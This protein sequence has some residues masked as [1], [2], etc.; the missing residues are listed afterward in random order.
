MKITSSNP[1]FQPKEITF[2]IESKDELNALIKMFG[3]NSTIPSQMPKEYKSFI[4]KFLS[5]MQYTLINY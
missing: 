1:N 4:T 2:L 5:D 3:L